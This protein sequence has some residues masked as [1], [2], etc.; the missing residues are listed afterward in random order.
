MKKLVIFVSK[1]LFTCSSSSSSKVSLIL[2]G[3]NESLGIGNDDRLAKF[4]K[5]LLEHIVLTPQL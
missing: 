2:R 4:E 3:L 5:F 1:F